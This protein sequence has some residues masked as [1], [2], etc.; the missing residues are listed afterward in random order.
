MDGFTL[1]ELVTVIVLMSIVSLAGVEIIRYT[2]DSYDKMMGRQTLGNSARI[3][4]DRISRELRAA[5]PGSARVANDCIEFIP[6]N[7]AGNYL[8][9]PVETAATSFQAV[10]LNPGQAA[11]TG[12]VAVYPVSSSVYNL[13]NNILSGNATV[14]APDGNN[15]IMVSMAVAHSF[16][17]ESPNRRFYLVADPVS[18]CVDGDNLFRYQNYGVVTTQ[19]SSAGLPA[20]LPDRALLVDKVGSS[21][22]PFAVTNVSLQRNAIVTVDLSFSEDGET[23]NILHEVQLRNVP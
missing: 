22:M 5:L 16:P 9:I 1:I 4:T 7:A 11:A 14:G 6:I 8:D 19:L 23:I 2:A 13:A 15:E 17:N 21:V 3:A 18:Y 10:P 20:S 12:R